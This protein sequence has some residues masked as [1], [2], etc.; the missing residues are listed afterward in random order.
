[1][2][3]L[4]KRITTN[5]KYLNPLTQIDERGERDCF[6][7]PNGCGRI[8][9]PTA[10]KKARLDEDGSHPALSN[11]RFLDCTFLMGPAKVEISASG[12]CL[13]AM[14]PVLKRIL[15]G[16]GCIAAVDPSVPIQWPDFDADAVRAVLQAVARR[17]KQEVTVPIN[18]V[19]SA[20]RFVDYLCESSEKLKLY[21]DTPFERELLDGIIFV[22]EY[23]KGFSRD[24]YVLP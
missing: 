5:M 24:D 3:S 17:G 6:D 15:Y 4:N 23:G 1:M 16:T 20:A 2:P 11:P 7:C 14:N 19:D 9:K 22:N 21:F 10:L 12:V 8:V 18:N 13:A